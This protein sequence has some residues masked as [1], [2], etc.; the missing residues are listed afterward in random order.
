MKKRDTVLT[1]I[2]FMIF[3]GLPLISMGKKYLNLTPKDDSAAQLAVLEGNGT[4][5]N[6]TKT[7]EANDKANEEVV[8]LPKIIQFRNSLSRFAN[9]IVFTDQ[10]VKAN[11]ELSYAISGGT[12]L[13]SNSVVVGEENFLF[14]K[15]TTDGDP[16]ADYKGTNLFTD[17]ELVEIGTNLLNIRDELS[18]RGIDFYVLAIPNKEQV[19]DRYMPVTIYRDSAYSRGMQLRDFICANSD[20]E[21][22]YPLDELKQLSTYEQAYYY[23]D[24]HETEIGAFIVYGQ[25]CTRRYG[26]AQDLSTAGFRI[27]LQYYTGDLGL[28]ANVSALEK[29]DTITAFYQT[30]E[31]AY[32]KHER[33]LFIGDS[34]TGYLSNIAT[35]DFDNVKRVSPDEFTMELLDEYRPHVVVFESAE[36]RLSVLGQDLLSQ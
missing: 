34:F 13:E 12:Y 32:R 33:I 28:I 7:E 8:E 17:E 25:L 14:Y 26:S 15:A 9:N 27:A 11:C 31:K 30:D 19:Y 36:R 5:A 16:I 4:L 22:I 3:M 6:T 2:F 24:T 18:L 20:I 10:F 29:L 21:F 35:Y 23:A 1:V